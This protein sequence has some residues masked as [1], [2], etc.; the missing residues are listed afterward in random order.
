MDRHRRALCFDAPSAIRWCFSRALWRRRR[1][2][3]NAL[4]ANGLSDNRRC[5][6]ALGSKGGAADDG[7]IWQQISRVPTAGADVLARAVRLAGGFRPLPTLKERRLMARKDG[8]TL[9]ARGCGLQCAPHVI[10]RLRTLV[11]LMSGKREHE[12]G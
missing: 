10:H 3:A 1:A 8:V 2:L 6:L 9:G 7:K 5:I 12:N 11:A 4:L